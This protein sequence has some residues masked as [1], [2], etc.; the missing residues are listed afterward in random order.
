MFAA[1][2]AALIALA[3]FT[4]WACARIADRAEREGWK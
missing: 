4:G 1:I 3:A 2:L